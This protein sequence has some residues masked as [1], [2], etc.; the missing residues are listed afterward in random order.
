MTGTVRADGA[1]AWVEAGDARVPLVAGESLH[2]GRDPTV[3]V[4]LPDPRISWRHAVIAAVDGGFHVRDLG[5]KNGTSVDGVPVDEAGVHLRAPAEIS[6]GGVVVSVRVDQASGKPPS[7]PDGDHALHRPLSIGRAPDNDIVLDEP[8]VSRYHAKV[9]PGSPPTVRDLGSRN[10]TRVGDRHVREAPLEPG[11]AIGIGPFQLVYDGRVLA[12]VDDRSTI[13]LRAVDVSVDVGAKRILHPTSLTVAPGDFVALIGQ[14]GSG[15][16][17]LLKSLAGVRPQTGGD[18][19]LGVDPVVLRQTDVGYVPQSE[20]IHDFLTVREALHYAAKLRL[21]SD[22]R[23]AELAA[24]V[25]EALG[26]L[27]LAEHGDTLIKSLSGGQ[28]KRAAAA[29]ELISKPTMLLLDE[30]TSGLDPGLER[31]FMTMLR[32]LA[33][34][35]RGVVVVTHA[36]RSLELCDRVVIMGDGGRLRFA[37]PPADALRQFGV[38]GFDEL[39]VILDTDRDAGDPPRQPRPPR[40]PV[41][42]RAGILQGRSFAQQVRVLAARYFRT[43]FRDRRTLAILLGQVPVIA[44][45]VAALFPASL[46]VRPDL[47]PNKSAQM[48]FL[49]IT[50]AIWLGLISACREIVKERSIVGREL[51]IGVRI[52]AYLAAKLV[53]LFAIT[54]IEVLLLVAVAFALQP[55]HESLSTYLSLTAILIGAAWASVGMGLVVSAIARSVDQATSF[56]P[57]LLIPQL[58]FAGALIPTSAMRPLLEPLAN[59]VFARWAFAGAGH[60]MHMGERLG[61]DARFARL[62]EFPPDFFTTTVGAT[63][64][65]LVGFLAAFMLATAFALGRRVGDPD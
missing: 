12:L 24:A 14:S 61:E 57:L 23:E 49:L 26:E 38:D 27:R 21:P 19:Y 22:T 63:A 31:R 29:A 54:A 62:N 8:N 1:R 36:T 48:L 41:R 64:L 9:L 6:L 52:D 30:P 55:L 5:S 34:Q 17:T 4:H 53:V 25:E 28:R 10:G 46:F 7:R 3:D 58:L 47:Q 33:D 56:V 59:V 13:S 35:G 60:A 43:V 32:G 45:C 51:T 42:Q 11:T 39:Y 20:T 50:A 15:K 37:G 18:V 40:T 44:F 16:T 2:L 65:I